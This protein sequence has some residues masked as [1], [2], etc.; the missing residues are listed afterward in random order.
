MS[1]NGKSKYVF[2]ANSMAWGRSMAQRENFINEVL[3]F[4]ESFAGSPEAIRATAEAAAGRAEEAMAELLSNNTQTAA[5]G[6]FG[7]GSSTC[8]LY[9]SPS[10]RD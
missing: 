7:A 5:L 6:L 8:L 9:T 3:S 10:P 4:L 1:T 2:S